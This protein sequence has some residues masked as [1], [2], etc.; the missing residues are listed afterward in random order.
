[1]L[2]LPGSWHIYKIDKTCLGQYLSH[3][4]LKLV[5][6]LFFK[7]CNVNGIWGNEGCA[8]RTFLIGENIFV[9]FVINVYCIN[10]LMKNLFLPRLFIPFN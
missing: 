2:F 8:D 5:R 4:I 9:F 7:Y 6:L 3:L 1:M 10:I